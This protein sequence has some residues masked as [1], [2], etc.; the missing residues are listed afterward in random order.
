M[1]H[2][3]PVSLAADPLLA[4]AEKKRLTQF[5]ELELEIGDFI[6]LTIKEPKLKAT[7]CT[8]LLTIGALCRVNPFC[9]FAQ[10]SLLDFTLR[11]GKLLDNRKN[12]YTVDDLREFM[13]NVG[14]YFT[15][16]TIANILKTFVENSGRIRL[17]EMKTIALLFVKKPELRDLFQEYCPAYQQ[18]DLEEVMSFD[19]FSRFLEE[20]Q[21]DSIDKRFYL[22]MLAQIKNPQAILGLPRTNTS[23]YLNFIEFTNILFSDYNLSMNPQMSKTYQDMDRPLCEYLINSMDNVYHDSHLDSCPKPLMGFYQALKYGARNL[24]IDLFDGRDGE[25]M[26]ACDKNHAVIVSLEDFLRCISRWAF[27]YSDYPLLLFIESHCSVDQLIKIKKLINTYLAESVY[28]VSEKEF[29]SE[30]F[31]S[32]MKLLKKIVIRTKSTYSHKK[33]ADKLQEKDKKR[34]L[35][36]LKREVLAPVTAMYAEKFRLHKMNTRFGVS[37]ISETELE[38]LIESLGNEELVEHH[39]KY[40][41]RVYQDCSFALPSRKTQRADSRSTQKLERRSPDGGPQHA[42]HQQGAAPELRHV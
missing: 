14:I 42:V 26:V 17:H 18:K 28:R 37:N 10:E 36:D 2:N 1:E 35:D 4:K 39:A 33:F 23:Q 21:K 40:L 9:K 19:Q 25:P 30:K 3:E 13:S 31:P 29:L 5:V 6:L 27:R 15:E 32:P 38:E 24:E 16:N 20:K 12:W 7:V 41:G 34:E 11:K 22:E 8:G